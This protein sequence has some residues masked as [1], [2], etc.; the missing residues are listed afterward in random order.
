ME[1]IDHGKFNQV[2]KQCYHDNYL[3]MS[4][5]ASTCKMDRLCRTIHAIHGTD[6]EY[7]QLTCINMTLLYIGQIHYN[8]DHHTHKQHCIHYV[9]AS[10]WIYCRNRSSSGSGPLLAKSDY[11]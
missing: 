9:A 10:P 8:S 11:Q 1:R 3:N 2:Y 4:I 5:H 7:C 6:I